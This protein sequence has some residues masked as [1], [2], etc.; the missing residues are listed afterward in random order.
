MYRI[1]LDGEAR[2]INALNQWKQ[3]EVIVYQWMKSGQTDEIM[4]KSF[5]KNF[6]QGGS[7]WKPLSP[8]TISDRL[9]KGYNSGPILVRTGN[10][11]DE[12]TSLRGKVTTASKEVRMEWGIDQ[13]R[14]GKEKA[15]FF[16]HQKGRGN[17][18]ARPMIGFQD[19]DAKR[20][21][22]SLRNFI[23]MQIK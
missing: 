19:I 8:S 3:I 18:P 6:S 12:V 13:I 23:L 16:T 14:A 2:V 17:I 7:N 10:L 4:Q 9:R 5:E 15:K 11:K 20:I 1:T 21:G 22:T